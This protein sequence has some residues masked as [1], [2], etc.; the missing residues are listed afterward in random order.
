MNLKLRRQQTVPAVRGTRREVK[1][2]LTTRWAET[3]SSAGFV[4]AASKRHNLCTAASKV[5]DFVVNTFRVK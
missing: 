2:L 5:A 4:A 1:H 3:E